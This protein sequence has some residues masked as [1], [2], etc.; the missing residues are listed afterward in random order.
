M[1][2]EGGQG[3]IID[4]GG[5]SPSSLES[6]MNILRSAQNSP[7]ELC[8]GPHNTENNIAEH[9]HT[10]RVNNTNIYCKIYHVV[11]YLSPSQ[12]PRSRA[13]HNYVMDS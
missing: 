3:Y 6:W 5:W 1:W 11:G 8:T 9:R 10:I 13:I 7:D 12:Q 2:E 4:A